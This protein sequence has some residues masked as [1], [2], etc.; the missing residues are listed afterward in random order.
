MNLLTDNI[1]KVYFKY[2]LA[3]MGSAVV[4]SIYSIVDTIAVGQYCGP[5]GTAAMAVISPIWSLTV[6]FGLLCGIGGAVLMSKAKGSGNDQTGNNFFTVAFISMIG[7]TAILWVLIILFRRNLFFL[8]GANEEIMPLV[9][10]YANWIVAFFPIFLL[11]PFLSAFIRNDNEPSLA[12]TAVIAGAVFNVFGDWF[13]VFPMDMGMTGAAL[14]TAIGNAIQL[15]ILCSHFFS[16]SCNLKFIKPRNLRRNMLKIF[17]AGASSGLLELATA[18]L[19]SLFNYKI[20]KYSGA[21]TLAVYGVI[22]TCSSLFQALFGG[23]GQAVQPIV[24]TNYGAQQSKR[25]QKTLRMSVITVMLI[26]VIFTLIG[27][28]FPTALVKLFMSATPEVLEIAPN[29]IRVYFSSF[30][31]MG[32]NVLSTYY[33]QSVMQTGLSL[34]ISLLRGIAISGLLVNVLPIVFGI[35][36][37]WWVMPITEL[38]IFFIAVFFMKNLNAR[39]NRKPNKYAID[40]YNGQGSI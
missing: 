28:L 25:I 9:L 29:I 34:T 13:F 26:G 12:M 16:K 27:F 10:E 11:S 14:A 39:N 32:I 8:F 20:M 2:L 37:I 18:I 23:V 6:F 31:F 30:L 1:R 3:S 38:I 7:I 36:S 19:I 22:C 5:D 35:T 4:T 40:G 24:S 21:T 17:S 33:L 15:I